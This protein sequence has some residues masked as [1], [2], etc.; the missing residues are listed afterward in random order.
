MFIIMSCRPR[1]LCLRLTGGDATVR[2]THDR[3]RGHNLDPLLLR[4]VL[5]LC[6]HRLHPSFSHW[7]CPPDPLHAPDAQESMGDLHG[8]RAGASGVKKQTDRHT[9]G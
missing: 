3:E 5:C 9:D 8:R 1:S 7:L 4:V 6:L 2:Q